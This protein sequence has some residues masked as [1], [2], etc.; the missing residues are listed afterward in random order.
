MIL[1]ILG[2]QGS[3]KG[4]QAKRLAAEF[5]LYYF[6]AG[7]EL[8]KIAKTDAR[9]NE[10]VNKRGELLP[11]LE[12]FGVVTKALGERT[13]NLILD[14]YPRSL[15]QFELITGWLANKG[16]KIAKAI[17]L[18]VSQ[19]ESIKRLSA[20]RSDPETGK[21]YNLITRP[22]GPGVDI[23][24]L[25]QREDDKPEAIRERLMVY[26]QTT[27]PLINK[28]RELGALIETDGERP[29]EEIYSELKK[30]VE[31]IKNEEV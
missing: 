14:G 6:D 3:G 7:A 2:P 9:I 28:L 21:I 30:K 5:G 20:R 8:R 18:R 15:K 23:T 31:S 22:P 29:V 10:I 4:T 19:P 26:H 25:I 17:Y 27:E 24:K 1:L 13:N 11:D 16:S 12:M